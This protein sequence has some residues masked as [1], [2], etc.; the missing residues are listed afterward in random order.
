[1]SEAEVI[2]EPPKENVHR[3]IQ[4]AI[5]ALGIEGIN[6]GGYNKDQKYHFRSI[7]QVYDALSE[8]LAEIGLLILPRMTSVSRDIKVGK[9]GSSIN[10]VNLEMEYRLTSVDDQSELVVVFPGEGMDWSDKATN[11]ALSNAYKYMCFEVFCIPFEGRDPDAES[12]QL[13]KQPESVAKTA[14]RE[15]GA[16]MSKKLS[17]AVSGIQ[18]AVFN[19]DAHGFYEIWDEM[20]NDEK[21]T[22]HGELNRAERKQIKVWQDARKVQ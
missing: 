9:G 21:T 15:S 8:V 6:K 3:K 7:D 16:P 20:D 2:E 22:V 12:P 1:M 17:E 4:R 18:M 5:E 11:K 10:V 13:G 19:D 14:A